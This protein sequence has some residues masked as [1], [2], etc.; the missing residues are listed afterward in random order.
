MK[1]LN[2]KY[3]FVLTLGILSCTGS[4]CYAKNVGTIGQ[5]YSIEEIDFLDFIQAR[6]SLMQ[7]NGGLKNLQQ[8]MQQRAI[9][10]R[11][12]PTPVENIT[13]TVTAKSWAFDPSIVLDHDVFT[14]DGKIIAKSGTRVNPLNYVPLSKTL[15]FYDA[16]DKNEVDWV[17]QLDS[18]LKGKDKLVVVKGSVLQEEKR[19]SK[20][21]YFDQSG[22]LTKR[23]GIE[24]VPATVTQEGSLLRISEVKP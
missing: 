11:D 10:Y 20:T 2:N 17:T 14:A 16:D 6:A 12:R 8:T 21:I 7:Q 24:H 22:K 18:K 5:I 15:I 19:L 13:H 9:S 4:F 1:I 23:F 3:L